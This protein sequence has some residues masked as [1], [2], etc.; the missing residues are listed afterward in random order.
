MGGRAERR[1]R[2]RY[3]QYPAGDVAGDAARR[4]QLAQQP[5][6]VWIDGQHCPPLDCPA[7]AIIGGDRD[8]SAIAAASILAKTDRDAMLV[9]L[10]RDVSCV[11]VLPTQGLF[12]TRASGGAGGARAVSCASPQLCPGHADCR[13]TSSDHEDSA[14][15]TAVRCIRHRR[16]LA[17]QHHPRTAKRWPYARASARTG[18]HSPTRGVAAT[19]CDASRAARRAAVAIHRRAAP[20]DSRRTCCANS[21]L[22]LN[23]RE[24]RDLNHAWHRLRPWPDSVKGLARLKRRYVIGTL[25]NGNVALLVDMAKHG[26]L[27]WDCVLS[28][29]LFR[30]LQ[31]RPGS[32]SGR[33]GAARARAARGH[34]GGRAQERSRGGAQVRIQYGVVRRPLE[35]GPRSTPDITDDRRCTFNCRRLRRPGAA[36]GRVGQP[37]ISAA[38]AR[39]SIRGARCSRARC[40]T[41]PARRCT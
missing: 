36:A 35:H 33:S 7:R 3:H 26:G 41:R 13:S 27:P 4:E 32:L 5:D 25:S 19:S 22:R 39:S 38:S 6:V 15:G 8:I 10:D 31:A 28:A 2:D 29:E 1:W 34:A 14:Q 16:R 37:D 12:D 9:E 17:R 24:K 40:A 11:W 30:H 21:G 23:E 20:H 18:Q